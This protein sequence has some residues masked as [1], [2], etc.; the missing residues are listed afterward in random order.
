MCHNLNA[1]REHTHQTN[2]VNCT[3]DYEVKRT[4]WKNIQV[5]TKSQPTSFQT[6]IESGL[7]LCILLL[8][9]KW[10]HHLLRQHVESSPH[11]LATETE[12][13]SLWISRKHLEV[14]NNRFQ[15]AANTTRLDAVDAS[16][17]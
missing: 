9:S 3:R 5:K 4:T 12:V 15:G 6:V 11:R 2:H 14:H 17:V 16:V 13:S 8:S 1:E 7:L 10:P